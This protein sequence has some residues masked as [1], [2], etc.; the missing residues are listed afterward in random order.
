MEQEN[1]LRK[2]LQDYYNSRP[3]PYKE[4]DWRQASAMLEAQRRKKRSCSFFRCYLHLQALWFLR[5]NTCPDMRNTQTGFRK[6]N[7]RKCHQ[8]VMQVF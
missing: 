6:T 4:E 7:V 2:T 1:K 8:P 5:Y 3:E